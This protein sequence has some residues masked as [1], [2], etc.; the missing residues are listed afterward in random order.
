MASACRQIQRSDTLGQMY[1]KLAA[2]LHNPNADIGSGQFLEA[3]EKHD[4]NGK[5]SHRRTTTS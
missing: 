2:W 3:Y 4:G 5:V 1:E